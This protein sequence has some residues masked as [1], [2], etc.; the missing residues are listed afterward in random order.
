[1]LVT[2]PTW[3]LSINHWCVRENTNNVAL[4]NCLISFFVTSSWYV[5]SSMPWIGKARVYWGL[6]PFFNLDF[7]F[8]LGTTGEGRTFY[9]RTESW[10]KSRETC[11]REVADQFGTKRSIK[12]SCPKKLRSFGRLEFQWFLDVSVRNFITRYYYTFEL[13]VQ[14]I[15]ES[16]VTETS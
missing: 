6:A 16:R 14:W 3:N 4:Q 5:Y 1:M 8:I 10:S 11:I 15:M 2:T 13:I 12:E 7:I 9:F